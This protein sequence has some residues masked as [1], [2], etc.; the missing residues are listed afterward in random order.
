MAGL[1][2]GFT[3]RSSPISRR[4]AEVVKAVVDHEERVPVR[5]VAARPA[6]AAR[7]NL[8]AASR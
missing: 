7:A 1:D 4:V 8:V 2:I 6:A 5:A 3:R